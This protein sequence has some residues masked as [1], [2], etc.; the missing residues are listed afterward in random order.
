MNASSITIIIMLNDTRPMKTP[1]AVCMITEPAIISQRVRRGQISTGSEISTNSVKTTPEA[2][3]SSHNSR[4]LTSQDIR[5]LY[6]F[7]SIGAQL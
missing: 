5:S 4:C 2:V 6:S 1:M 3:V 7:T